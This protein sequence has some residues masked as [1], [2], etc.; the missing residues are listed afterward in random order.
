MTI[1]ICY[2]K[3]IE[4]NDDDDDVVYYSQVVKGLLCVLVAHLI[5][6]VGQFVCGAHLRGQCTYITL[7]HKS[8]VLSFFFQTFQITALAMPNVC[9]VPL[10]H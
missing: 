8:P 2:T 3:K 6:H 5:R 7:L 1:V 9:S 4:L 10:I